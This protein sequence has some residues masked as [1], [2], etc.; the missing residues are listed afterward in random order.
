[1]TVAAGEII[2]GYD[3]SEQ[4]RDALRAGCALAGP[5]SLLT[6]VHAYEVPRQV[7]RYP[8]FAD[9]E[10][11]CREVAQEI[12]DSAKD[13]V[14]DCD[15][16]VR[17]V[18]GTGKPADVLAE[19]AGQGSA[20]LIVVGSRR[21]GALRAAVGSVTQRLIHDSPCPVLV[22]PERKQTAG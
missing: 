20:K 7:A 4:S 18:T 21:L 17:Y 15:A 22:V 3:G 10:D 11:A 14:G 8:F 13:C 12:V 6:V 1:V 16:E 9:F 19:M 2:V 5:D